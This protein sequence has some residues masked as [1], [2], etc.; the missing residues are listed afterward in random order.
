MSEH[1]SQTDSSQTSTKRI[2]GSCLC[3]NAKY[4]LSA[5]HLNAN[6]CHC[7]S[8]KKWSGSSFVY[9]V[10]F[11]LS[12]F[13]LD[14]SEELKVYLD[15]KTYSGRTIHRHFCGTC[16]S[17][18]YCSVPGSDRVVICSGTIDGPEGVGVV[19]N[20][21][22]RLPGMEPKLEFFCKRSAPWLETGQTAEKHHMM[23]APKV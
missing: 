8:C 21:E 16:G 15:G 17:G 5:P 13:K 2:T 14:T 22:A 6:L 9:N 19:D 10:W 11:P 7:L 3:G 23:P 4:T 18:V 12:A 1:Q 20:E